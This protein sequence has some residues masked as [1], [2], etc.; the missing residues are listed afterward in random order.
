[1]IK[2]G[3]TYDNSVGF[4]NSKFKKPHEK[5][6]YKTKNELRKVVLVPRKGD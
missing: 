4:A 1:M 5:D 2:F 3:D 6:F